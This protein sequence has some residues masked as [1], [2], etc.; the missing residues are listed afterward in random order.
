MLF[1]MRVILPLAI[2]ASMLSTFGIYKFLQ[3]KKAEMDKPKVLTQDVVIAKADFPIGKMLEESDLRLSNWPKEIVPKGSY[4][5][6][7]PLIGRVV[8][9]EVYE[10][11]AI[12]E[13]KL[14]PVGSDGGFSSVIPPGMRAVTVSVN[15]Y[16]GVSG[17]ILPNTYVDVF[18]TVPSPSN[19]EE[20]S[21]KIILENVKV[22]AVDQ[23]F[24]REGDDPV[25][26]QSVTLLVTPDEAEKLVLASTEGKLQLGLRN[27]ADQSRRQTAGVQLREL[28]SQTA[29]RRPVSRSPRRTTSRPAQPESSPTVVEVIRSNE[30]TEVKFEEDKEKK[31][32]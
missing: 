26:V 31:K 3:A 30:R 25:I 21:T 14:A 32:K 11:E 16:S 5:E 1:K 8:R 9:A 27:T 12:L 19:K 2:I 4:S 7:S 10:G 15:T 17:F 6:A 18:V 20:S 24:E 13:S 28:M 22:L 29:A 23:T